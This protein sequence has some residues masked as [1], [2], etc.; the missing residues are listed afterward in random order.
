[1]TQR[2]LIIGAGFGGMWA[3]L[4]AARALDLAGKTDGSIEIAVVAPEATL[5]IRPRYYEA[6][7]GSM[8]APIGELLEVAG[9]RFI[10]GKVERIRTGLREVDIIGADGRSS[11]LGYDRLVLASGSSLANPNLPGLKA[12]AFN[13]DQRDE[14]VILETHLRLLAGRPADASRNT[15]VVVGGGFTGIETAADMPSRVRAVLGAQA[16]V[17]VVLVERAEQIGPELGAG[18]RPVILQ[19]LEHDGVVVRLGASVTQVDEGGV[20]LSNGERIAASTVVWTAGPVA[21]ALTQQVPGRRDAL[22][23]LHTA[24]DLR[25]DGVEHVFAAGDVALAKT[26]DLGHHASMSCQHAMSLGRSAGHNAA[27][28]LLGQPTRPYRQEKYVTCLDLGPW[29]A[30]LT[31]G[32]DRKVVLQGVEA[33]QLKQQINSVWIYP[34][35]AIRAEALAAADPAR[36]VVA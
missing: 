11:S 14:A 32:W 8:A 33:K 6:D 24:T 19:A 3:A 13:V 28:D 12:H 30:V 7:P 2:I 18:P 22:G 26:D 20:N 21:S 27:C 15:V 10:A 36:L 4:A 25:V 35:P 17:R 5:G 9:V 1:M 29:G 31:E 34:P 16:D 23:R